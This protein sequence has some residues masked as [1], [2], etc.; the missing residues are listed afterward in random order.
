MRFKLL[1]GKNS[2]AFSLVEVLVYIAIFVVVSI[3]LFSVLTTVLNIERGETTRVE[4]GEQLS[5]ISDSLKYLIAE[6]SLVDVAEGVPVEILLLR[7]NEAALDPT[8]VYSTSGA[9]YVKEGLASPYA[10][11]DERVSVEDLHFQ[12]FSPAG[13]PAV[14]EIS[15]TLGSS[16]PNPR[17]QKSRKLEIAFSRLYAATFDSDLLPSA[18]NKKIGQSS[19]S[20]WERILVSDGS[21]SNPSYSFGNNTSIGFFRDSG[22]NSL[23]VS[24]GGSERFR[25]DST[26]KVGIG[27]SSPSVA[28]DVSGDIKVSGVPGASGNLVCVKTDNTLGTCNNQ[29]TGGTCT[30]Q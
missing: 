5:Y 27:L 2:R 28:L 17:S 21:E 7:R 26:G 12:K 20:T 24:V 11:T 6:T 1:N 8:I 9:L 15:V 19:G 16:N 22:S 23:A 29:P 13:G 10:L 4:V 30:C 3:S 14:V 25:I 18:A